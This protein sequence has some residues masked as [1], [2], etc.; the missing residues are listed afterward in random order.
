VHLAVVVEGQ[1]AAVEGELGVEHGHVRDAN[2][3][4]DQM[5]AV[6]VTGINKPI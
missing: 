2:H 6:L 4:G 3:V 1:L 5:L